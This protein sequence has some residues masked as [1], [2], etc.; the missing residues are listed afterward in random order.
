MTQSHSEEAKR[1]L[2]HGWSESD[3][4]QFLALRE[5]KQRWGG[6]NLDREERLFLRG[7]ESV[8]LKAGSGL[9]V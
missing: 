9:S 5:Y 6:A 8:L 2:S 1:L 7:A 4:S 3:V